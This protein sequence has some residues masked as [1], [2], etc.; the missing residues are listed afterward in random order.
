[1]RAR[2]S[3]HW[4]RTEDVRT[5]REEGTNADRW[6]IGTPP[7][8]GNEGER[9]QKEVIHGGEMSKQSAGERD[10]ESN[11]DKFETRIMKLE[12]QTKWMYDRMTAAAEPSTW[13]RGIPW[14]Y[15]DEGDERQRW[16]GSW[17]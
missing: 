5:I 2:R 1:M 17:N 9:S 14:K 16:E 4:W 8:I 10:G 15:E 3:Q 12:E 6:K 13:N 7:G 11:E